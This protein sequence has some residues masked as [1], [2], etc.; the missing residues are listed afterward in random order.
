MTRPPARLD[1]FGAG[2]AVVAHAGEN[3][4]DGHRAR[5][6][7]GGFHGDIDVGQIAVDAAGS[8]VELN[9]ARRSDAQVLAAGAN[10]E[11][12]GLNGFVGFGFFHANAGEL[13]ELRRVLRGER[14]RHVLH[15]KNGSGK[16]AREAGSET[17]DRCGAAGGGAQNDDGKAL[18]EWPRDVAGRARGG[19]RG[20]AWRRMLRCCDVLQ[21]WTRAATRCARR[22]PLRTCALCAEDLRARFAC[23]GRCR[24]MA[25]RQIRWRRVRE[26]SACWRRLRGIRS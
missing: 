2:C 7:R 24:S 9:A 5:E 14:R 19:W 16:V 22:E 8:R 13:G 1:G 3:D 10:V 18:I 6:G 15:E 23:R 26:L 17:H 11:R 12:A 4:A 20:F 21:A 25:W